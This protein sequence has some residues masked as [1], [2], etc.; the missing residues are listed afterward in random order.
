M[1]LAALI[2]MTVALVYFV[3]TTTFD[4]YPFNNTRDATSSEKRTEVAVNAPVIAVPIVLLL[5][6]QAFGLPWPAYIG[7]GV[8][9][10][11][12]VG[13]LLLWWAPYLTGV[14]MPWAT[15]G[16]GLSWSE[17]HARTYAHTIIVLP[18]ISDR[19]RPNLEHMILHTLFIAAGIFAILAGTTI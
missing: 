1:S 9:L 10:L 14:T 4:L 15:A 18:R 17:L 3:V 19:P 2:L 8:E 11:V 6:A 7:G 13:G 16:T 5:C 12:A